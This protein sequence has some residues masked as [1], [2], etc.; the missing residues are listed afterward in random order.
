MAAENLRKRLSAMLREDIDTSLK[1]MRGFVKKEGISLT[2]A[3]TA[4][5][6]KQQ[7]LLDILNL[8]E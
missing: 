2:D 4:E 1:E 7:T 3:Y 5:L 6:T 8:I